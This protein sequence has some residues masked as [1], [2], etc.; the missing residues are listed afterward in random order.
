MINDN[1][2]TTTGEGTN[3]S[4]E[5]KPAETSEKSAPNRQRRRRKPAV[6]KAEGAEGKEQQE[7]SRQEKPEKQKPKKARRR[8]RPN[9]DVSSEDPTAAI[10]QRIFEIDDGDV[11]DDL[12]PILPILPDWSGSAPVR[13]S[14]STKPVKKAKP[15]V[16]E[17]APAPAETAKKTPSA[18]KPK[19]DA[20]LRQAILD[21]LQEAGMPQ[22]PDALLDKLAVPAMDFYAALDALEASGQVFTTRKQRIALPSQLGYLTGKIHITSKGFGFLTPTDGSADVFVAQRDLNTAID[23]DLVVLRLTGSAGHSRDGEIVA[24]IERARQ[25]LVGRFVLES[26]SPRFVPDDGKAGGP[27]PA[28]NLRRNGA[29]DGQKVVCEM[30]YEQ[31]PI[32]A[33]VTEVLGW[34]DEAGTDVLSII[35]AHDIPEE[36]PKAVKNAARAVPEEISEDDI[37]RRED[38]R[39]Y[40]IVTID[41]ADAKDFDDAISL[42]KLKNGNF[43]LGV[44]IADVAHYVKEGTALDKEA[45]KR[46]TSVY[47]VDRVIPMLPEELSNGICSLNPNEDRLTL[48]CFMEIDPRGN[49]LSHRL[50][51]TV[52]RSSY[53]LVYEDVTRLLEGDAKLR[54]KYK[55]IVPLLTNMAELFEILNQRRIRRGSLEFDLPEC[56]IL[57]DDKGKPV[58][59][60][61]YERGISNRIIEEFMLICNETVA[62]HMAHLD[63]P[64]LYRVHEVPDPD[65]VTELGAFMAGFGLTLRGLKNGLHPKSL[66]AA[67]SKVAGRPEEAIVNRVALRSLKKA[68][69]APENLGHF[70]LA[71]E[72]YCHFTSPIRRYPDLVVHRVVKE[73]LRGKLTKKRFE[74][75]SARMPEYAEQTSERERAAMEA[76][77]EVDDLKKCEYMALHVGERFT[78]VI[79]GV[80]SFGLFVELPNTC[81]GLV[82]IAE[83]SDDYYVYEEKNYR[84]VGRH[85]KNI[86]RLG[87][88]VTIEVTGADPATRRVDFALIPDNPP[89]GKNPKKP[90]QGAR[91]Q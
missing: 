24:V 15:K 82:R 4:S 70:G 57:L 11:S 47:F 39:Q 83:M 65:R 45:L 43:L 73:T 7:H 88:T 8:S 17:I 89:K 1:E 42:E 49:V 31:S 35:R 69:Y 54:K 87:D 16:E 44:H 40:T 3:V 62:E 50:S 84:Y 56:R 30:D 63:L 52:I 18:K 55:P 68:R 28:I 12:P 60:T 77:R 27:Y 21:S 58:D 81:E 80:T 34:P 67:L 29:K 71:A 14:A 78:G 75:L 51:E 25:T 72:F 91:R 33:R 66:Q 61:L 22:T 13:G 10:R 6:K 23:G 79:S 38:L 64:L 26:G 74:Q 76:E 85:R 20:A 2:I 59:V 36:F 19:D 5:K 86:Y 90:R 41:G 46:G 32:T 37:L 48:S 53:R 9:Q